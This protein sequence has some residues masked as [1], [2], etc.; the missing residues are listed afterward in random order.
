MNLN[1]IIC[2]IHWPYF[3][4]KGEPDKIQKVRE[5]QKLEKFSGLMMEKTKH[6]PWAHLGHSQCKTLSQSLRQLI[7]YYLWYFGDVAAYLLKKEVEKNKTPS[8]I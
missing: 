4:K 5:K 2:H 6:F 7:T 1:G 3:Q 8:L